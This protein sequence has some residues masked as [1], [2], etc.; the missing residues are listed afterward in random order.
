M[1]KMNVLPRFFC[2]LSK[3]LPLLVLAVLL[4]GLALSLFQTPVARAATFIYV[5]PDGN[6]AYCDGTT[7]DPYPGSGTGLSCAVQTIQQGIDLVDPGGTV[8]VYPG[9]YSE[10]ASNRILF[11]GSGPYQFG[12]FIGQDKNGIT[13]QGVDNSDTA[14]THF[15]NVLATVNTNATNNFGPSGIF[16]EGDNVTIAGLRVGTNSTGQNKTIEVIGDNFTL[17]N[18]DIAD[19]QGSVYLNDWRFD[20]GTNT[21]HVQ[22]YH[23]EGNNFQDGISLDLASGAGF[24]GPVSGRTITGNHFATNYYWPSISFNGSGTGVPWFVD[25]VGGAII[26]ANTFTNTAA[27]GQLIRARGDYDNTQFDW[28]SYWN[29]NSFNKAVMVGLNPPADVRTYSYTS[30]SY[31]FNNV[32]RIGAVIQPEIEHGVAGDTVLVEAGIYK[33]NVNVNKRVA[34]IGAGS[35]NTAT[36]TIVTTPTS[37]DTKV[38]VFQVSASG[39]SATEPILLQD[40]R[41][42]PVGQAGIS[43]GR[44]TEA[45]GTNVSYLTLDNVFVIGTNNN[46]TTEQERGL[47]VDLTSTLDHLTV[48][49]S[50][51]NN[52]VYGWYLMKQVSADTSTVG[53]VVVTNT[54]FNHNNLKGIYAEKLTDTSFTNCTISENGFSATGV[55][56]YFLPWMS[57]VDINLKAGTYQNISFVNLTVM[58]NGLG[59][60]KEGVGLAV[61]ARSDGATYGPFPAT[62]DNVLIT[63]GIFTGNERGIRIGEPTKNNPGPTNVE[64]HL[65]QIFGNIQTYTGTDGSAYGGV[66]NQSTAAVDAE[67]NWWGSQTGP[68]HS[69]NPGGMGNSVSDNVTFTPW[70]CDGTDTSSATGFQPNLI[71]SSGG[72]CTG[73]ITIIKQSEPAGATGFTFGGDLGSFNLNDGGSKVVTG[74]TSGSYTITEIV[75]SDWALTNVSCTGG[76]S[77]A[78]LN[79]ITVQLAPGNDVSCTFLN[80]QHV[81]L[82][83]YDSYLPLIF[84]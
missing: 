79:G 37:F 71:L 53:N 15:N 33:E 50:A 82:E 25:S 60:A 34:I 81:E 54:T 51:F 38:G 27:D 69:S 45:T 78:L 68:T 20:T 62:L 49:D 32:R 17:K 5:R 42:Q 72:R 58:N 18:S 55:P 6:N 61:K 8:R 80:Q 19:L 44:F 4:T 10:T 3:E 14:I 22:G 1:K 77:I 24:S 56:S 26:Q 67:N 84:K 40:L 29:D 31:T 36:D 76:S 48:T 75:S 9:D 57:G 28:A 35:G 63:N 52:L 41:L 70:L 7:S 83:Q 2:R 30:G 73:S 11:D 39:L 47:Y 21:S 13:I 23:F 16:V 74:L 43:V 12:L 59:G 65:N 66:V 64:I 46:A